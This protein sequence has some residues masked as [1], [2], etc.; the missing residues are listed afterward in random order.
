MPLTVGQ[1]FAKL[2][3]RS[4]HPSG[5]LGWTGRAVFSFSPNSF[6]LEPFLGKSVTRLVL[7]ELRSLFLENQFLRNSASAVSTGRSV[8]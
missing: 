2:H 4:H 7:Q 3:S 8:A 1:D 5:L 6:A